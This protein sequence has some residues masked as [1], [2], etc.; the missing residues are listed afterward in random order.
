M[1]QGTGGERAPLPSSRRPSTPAH[2]RSSPPPLVCAL[3]PPRDALVGHP[4]RRCGVRC[5]SSP[6]HPLAGASRGPS[7]TS[8]RALLPLPVLARCRSLPVFCADR[9]PLH[10][11]RGERKK[12]RARLSLLPAGVAALL[13]SE[14][15][16]VLGSHRRSAASL[17]RAARRRLLPPR[18]GGVEEEEG[19]PRSSPSLP[20]AGVRR[21][22]SRV[23]GTRGV[24]GSARPSAPPLYCEDE[25]E[26]RG[27]GRAERGEN[28]LWGPLGPIICFVADI[29]AHVGLAIFKLFFYS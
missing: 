9:A 12:R 18:R 14:Y 19:E 11:E 17:L 23:R 3:P 27:R 26:R 29:W 4:L 20:P 15:T 8:S 28:D 16:R 6:S 1:R 7:P 22:S 5:R 13:A 24:L 10:R 2:R 25:G 21:R